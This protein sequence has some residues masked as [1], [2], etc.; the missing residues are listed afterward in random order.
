VHISY[1]SFSDTNRLSVVWFG[2]QQPRLLR[3][4]MISR[5]NRSLSFKVLS[6]DFSFFHNKFAFGE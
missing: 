2:L 4:F 1:V 6:H 3:S 5:F